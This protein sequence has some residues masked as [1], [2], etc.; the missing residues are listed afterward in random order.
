MKLDRLYLGELQAVLCMEKF[1]MTYREYLRN[2]R[3]S[4]HLKEVLRFVLQGLKELHGIGYVHRDLKPENI[5]ISLR[6]LSV[7]IIDFNRSIL[8]K[9]TTTGTSR[10]TPGYCP[11]APDLADGSI[12][13]DVWSLAA[14][15]LESDMD[16]NE[17]LHVMTERGALQ[18]AS[19]YLKEGTKCK[20]LKA[21]I[22]GTLL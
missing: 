21:L 3:D 7:R 13:W 10:G 18:K 19:E 1:E 15:I 6:P 20:H 14:I 11:H 17:Y 2:H 16:T 8:T 12:L 5:V 4:R 9:V 22:K